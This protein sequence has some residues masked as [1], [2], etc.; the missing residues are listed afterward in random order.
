MFKKI[1][2]PLDLTDHHRKAVD[3]AAELARQGGGEVTLL[4]VIE[5]IPGLPM[6]EEKTFYDRLGRVGRKHL[7]KYGADLAERQVPWRAKVLF[8][9]R[10]AEIAGFAKESGADLI[11]LTAPRPDPDKPAAGWGS[12][13]LKVGVAAECPVLLVK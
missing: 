7:D 12:M 2:V 5:V 6:E 10:A 4:H 11:V 9:N 1:L 13:S 8:G 3:V